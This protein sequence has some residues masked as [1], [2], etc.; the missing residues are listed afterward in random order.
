MLIPVACYTG[1]LDAG[2]AALAPLRTP[3]SPRLDLIDPQAVRRAPDDV[4]LR[5]ARGWGYYWKSHYLPPLHRRGHRRDRRARLAQ[6]RRPRAYSV[7]FHLGGAVA[8]RPPDFNASA[9]GD[10]THAL[11]INA[12]GRMADRDHADIGWCRAYAEAMAPHATGGVY[13]N[14]LHDE[15]EARIR[16]AYGTRY[17][18]LAAIKGRYD[19]D[20]V[21]RS[22][23]N[24]MPAIALRSGSGRP[25]P[26]GTEVTDSGGATT[27]AAGRDHIGRRCRAACDRDCGRP[28]RP[29]SRPTPTGT[30]TPS[31]RC[32]R[33][34]TR[35]LDAQRPGLPRLHGRRPVR[36]VAAPR[37]PRAAPPPACSAIRTRPTR[38]RDAATASRSGA[39][40]RVLGFLRR[41]RPT[42]T[43]VVFTANASAALQLVGEAYP[44]A[45]GS[46]LC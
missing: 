46:R 9:A 7:L 22:N 20:N 38:P 41:R 18:R 23:Q 6:A 40:A 45:P 15:G 35:R 27:D 19:P 1:D 37:A 42:S 32:A 28:A 43:T 36:R 21:F 5:R 2:E 13:V 4:R 12:S 31:R 10:A 30:G 33:A 14:F 16:A 25:G 39:R 29:A 11:N 24:I 8:E 17:D 44:F 34:S 3:S 26:D